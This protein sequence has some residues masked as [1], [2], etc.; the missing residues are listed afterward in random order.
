M[1]KKELKRQF[2]GVWM[3][4]E[5]YLSAELTA[6]EKLVLIEIN[7][8]DGER[9]HCFASNKHFA[10]FFGISTRHVTKIL[11]HL[12]E[13]KFIRIEMIGRN[14]REI[15]MELQFY[16][17]TNSSSITDRTPVPPTLKNT[18]EKDN[19]TPATGVA[20][21]E[22]IDLF[23]SVNPSWRTLFARKNQHEAVRRMITSH[24]EEKLKTIISF[25]PRNNATPFAPKITT[26][27]QLED[28]MGKLKAFWEQQKNKATTKSKIAFV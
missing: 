15:L 22:I 19:E 2:K 23:Q 25:L 17:P 13:L 16:Q 14:R 21:G 20:E 28:G 8:L 7:S 9:D 18:N 10:D 4:K 1:D 26:P 5:I 27:I 24:G 11:A 12:A 6:M 3:P